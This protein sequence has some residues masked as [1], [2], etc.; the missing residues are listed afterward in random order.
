VS[1]E[2]LSLII[3]FACFGLVAYAAIQR[4]GVVD[5]LA[6]VAAIR[7]LMPYKQEE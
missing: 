5:G 6:I 7:M 2:G 3:A 4:W 1:R